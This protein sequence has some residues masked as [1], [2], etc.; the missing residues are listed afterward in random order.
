MFGSDCVV[1][2]NTSDVF[3]EASLAIW[4][5]IDAVNDEW[6]ESGSDSDDEGSAAASSRSSLSRTVRMK[7][8]QRL[9]VWALKHC[10]AG[11]AVTELLALLNDLGLDYFP[12]SSE[13]LLRTPR[14][15]KL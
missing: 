4:D 1:F 3:F 9:S 8:C 10:I 14:N 5:H 7:N 11:T 13:T 12:R 15:V 6:P 2:S